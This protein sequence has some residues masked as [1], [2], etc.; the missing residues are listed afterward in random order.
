M[1]GQAPDKVAVAC[2][3][4]LE[5]CE[6]DTHELAQRAVGALGGGGHCDD[7]E[8]IGER[9]EGDGDELRLE[10]VFVGDGQEKR[11][12]VVLQRAS[13]AHTGLESLRCEP[14]AAGR[15]SRP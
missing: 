8:A 3:R 14:G 11:G 1:S 4:L 7:L 2:R 12:G 9:S 6:R 5:R 10:V 13:G 15:R